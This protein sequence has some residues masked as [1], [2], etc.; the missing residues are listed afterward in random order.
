[1]KN[2]KLAIVPAVL[3]VLIVGGV[4]VGG[5]GAQ[6][7]IG[8]LGRSAIEKV[9]SLVAYQN[10]SETQAPSRAAQAR[11][12]KTNA[13]DAHGVAAVPATSAPSA[14][15]EAI[16][17][18]GAQEAPAG[19]TA[20]PAGVAEQMVAMATGA[21]AEHGARFDAALG[22]EAGA[23]GEESS[24]PSSVVQVRG[25]ATEHGGAD[26]S[27]AHAEMESDADAEPTGELRASGEDYWDDAD[28]FQFEDEA[29]VRDMGPQYSS[30]G[31]RDP[32][33]ALVTTM[34][35]SSESSD[36]VD[37]SRLRLVGVVWG[38]H[39]ICALVED[40]LKRGYV[41]REGDRVLYGR[42]ASITRGSIVIDQM[43]YGEFKRVKLYLERDKGRK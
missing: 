32:F 9:V 14:G 42:V 18:S 39:G 15:A 31:A 33:D 41:L 6:K 20:D 35:Q 13:A 8:A 34:E 25:G 1:M 5:T 37:P 10:R 30:F 16:D 17:A 19:A 7:T 27:E 11:A 22:P 28:P 43:I 38:D 4:L 23:G 21:A 2:K 26:E 29:I 12:G 36:I 24:E 40:D 3:V